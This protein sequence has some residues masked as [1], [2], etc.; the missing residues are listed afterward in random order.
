MDTWQERT[1]RNCW[2]QFLSDGRVITWQRME[3]IKTSAGVTLAVWWF[4]QSK[5]WQEG[6]RVRHDRGG[7]IKGIWTIKAVWT[8]WY[9][10]F[11]AERQ[12]IAQQTSVWFD[13]N[14]VLLQKSRKTERELPEWTLTRLTRMPPWFSFICSFDQRELHCAVSFDTLSHTSLINPNAVLRP[15]SWANARRRLSKKQNAALFSNTLELNCNIKY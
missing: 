5:C 13:K 2:Q 7:G 3:Q 12:R 9:R 11:K 1:L 6:L 15:A 14:K 8:N 4:E 10:L